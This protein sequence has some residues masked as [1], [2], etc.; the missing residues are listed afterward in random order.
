[1][2]IQTISVRF[3]IANKHR[4]NYVCK[5]LVYKHKFKSVV[6]NYSAKRLHSLNRVEWSQKTIKTHIDLFLKWGWCE[7]QGKDLVFKSKV[8]LSKEAVV[9]GINSKDKHSNYFYKIRCKLDY[10][11]IRTH[12]Y[13]EVLKRKLRQMNF[14]KVQK[15]SINPRKVMQNNKREGLRVSL[16]KLRGLF[17]YKSISSVKK[18]IEQ[19]VKQRLVGKKGFRPRK[20]Y[21]LSL[22]SFIFKNPCTEYYL[23]NL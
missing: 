17:G 3:F 12:L 15:N 19:G 18:R 14:R 6:Y 5:F 4:F 23:P 21:S 16:N 22:G 9:K 20:V 1:M 2:R 7:K 13:A 10:K 8:Q 11:E